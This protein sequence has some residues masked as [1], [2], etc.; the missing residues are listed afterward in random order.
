MISLPDLAASVI[1]LAGLVN[2]PGVFITPPS[3]RRWYA[4]GAEPYLPRHSAELPRFLAE[5][6]WPTDGWTPTDRRDHP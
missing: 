5:K 3:R 4:P 2:W 1:L 6:G